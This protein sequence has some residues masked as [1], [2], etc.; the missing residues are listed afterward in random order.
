MKKL[1]SNL[2]RLILEMFRC[3]K[4]VW[5]SHWETCKRNQ[6]KFSCRKK[7]THTLKG[8]MTFLNR[9]I[10]I[11]CQEILDFCR[12]AYRLTKYADDVK[13]SS[14]CCL[15]SHRTVLQMKGLSYKFYLTYINISAISQ[16]CYALSAYITHLN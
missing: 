9:S 8:K 7:G 2:K 13:P 15:N 3:A 4:H 1:T 10:S 6:I 14:K 16:K 12:I 5:N 11:F